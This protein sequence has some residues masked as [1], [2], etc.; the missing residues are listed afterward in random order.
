MV[1]AG[2]KKLA[3][4]F[5]CLFCMVFLLNCDAETPDSELYAL[6]PPPP[7]PNSPHEFYIPKDLEDC[8]VELKKMLPPDLLNDIRNRPLDDVLKKYHLNLGMWLRNNWGLWSG[9]RLADYFKQKG[10]NILTE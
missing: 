10:S 1:A 4:F 7:E 6:K 8:F 3:I 2:V 5:V 9:S